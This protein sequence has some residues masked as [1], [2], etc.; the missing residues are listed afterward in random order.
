MVWGVTVIIIL[1]TLHS[2]I[3]FLRPHS[4][5]NVHTSGPCYSGKQLVR[6]T[7]C[8]GF[9]V[10]TM[11][12]SQLRQWSPV[13][14]VIWRLLRGKTTVQVY[15]TQTGTLS[16][17]PSLLAAA[18]SACR[19]STTRIKPSSPDWKP[20]WIRISVAENDSYI[21]WKPPPGLSIKSPCVCSPLKAFLPHCFTPTSSMQPCNHH[22]RNIWSRWP[23]TSSGVLCGV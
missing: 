14:C 22:C 6:T 20:S 23:L 3:L 15:K 19:T 12:L 1:P 9:R 16:L 11:K 13:W 4:R 10:E 17:G 8:H 21:I 2:A 7:C 18:A 5:H